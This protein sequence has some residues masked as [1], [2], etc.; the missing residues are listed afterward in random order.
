MDPT[1]MIVPSMSCQAGCRYCFGPHHGAIMDADTA[2]ETVRFVHAAAAE[3]GM[4]EISV[5]FHGG[6]PLLAPYDIWELLFEGLSCTPDNIPVHFSVQSN[7]WQLDDRFLDLFARYGAVIGTSLDGPSDICDLNRGEGYFDRTFRSVEKAVSRGQSVGVIA[8]LTKQTIPR[9]REVLSFFREQ[10]MNPVL[11]AAVKGMGSSEDQYALTAGEYADCIID[12]Y[13]WYVKNRKYFSVPTLDNYCKAVVGGGA[14]V[15]TMQDCLGMFLAISPSGDITGCQRMSGDPEYTLGNIFD[16]PSV[17]QLMNSPAAIRLRRRQEQ[18]E[19]RCGQ[20]PWL[21]MCRGG[22]YYNAISMGDGIIDPMCEAYKRIYD[23]LQSRMTDEITSPE[24]MAAMDRRPPRRDEN[25]ILRDGE[26]I[27]LSHRVHPSGVAENARSILA[28]HALGK[29]SDIR[30]AAEYMTGH[31]FCAGTED[32]EKAL[33]EMKNGLERRRSKLNNCYI[34]TTFRCNLRCTHCYACAGEKDTEMPVEDIESLA[35]QALAGGFRQLVITG[36]EPLHHRDRKRLI[37]SCRSLRS[38]GSNIVLRTNL[39]GVFTDG[40]LSDIAAAFDQVVV[41]IDGSEQTHDA[42]RGRGSYSSAVCNCERYAAITAD[43]IGAGELS[44]ACVMSAADING[45]PGQSV[46]RLAVRLGVSRIRFRPLLPLGRAAS[47]GEP[48]FSECINQY[49]AVEDILCER[50]SP[51]LSCGIGQNIYISPDGE[52][53]PCYAWQTEASRLGNVLTEGLDA[54][55]TAPAFTRLRAC[56]VDTIDRCRSCEIRYLC[57]G[58]CRAW[59]NQDETDPDTA[60]P[61]C[62][63]LQQRAYQLLD[64]AERY[65]RE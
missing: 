45:D 32:T 57:G 26:Y 43:V 58:A 19:Q 48:V 52:S 64:A 9:A 51:M 12:L 14:Q 18:V 23:F 10:G 60:P 31:H 46:R 59:G 3:C 28:A 50:F 11:H 34:H 35:E 56:T 13:P 8:T 61:V 54:V 55:L 49:E 40:E 27:S 20:C 22:C 62:S 4:K 39:T 24:N 65:L 42:R 53:Y 5:I 25:P 41:S 30:A 29:F 21:D 37:E 44:L 36:G 15:C 1:F 16:R 17:A 47:S 33:A 63:H 2:A 7:L 38:R 6:E